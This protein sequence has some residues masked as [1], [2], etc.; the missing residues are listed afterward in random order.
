MLLLACNIRLYL[1]LCCMLVKKSGAQQSGGLVFKPEV[2]QCPSGG[3]IRGEWH[4]FQLTVISNAGIIL[5]DIYGQ[6]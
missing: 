3:E 4:S 5:S 6:W 1:T 2:H